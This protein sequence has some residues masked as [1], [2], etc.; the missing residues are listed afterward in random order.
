MT[1]FVGVGVGARL[2]DGVHLDLKVLLSDP[3]PVRMER[4]LRA[5]GCANF[6]KVSWSLPANHS[7]FERYSCGRGAPGMSERIVRMDECPDPS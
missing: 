6:C 2:D 4:P 7:V 5:D 3:P 1:T